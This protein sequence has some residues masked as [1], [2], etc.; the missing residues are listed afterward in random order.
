MYGEIN[1]VVICTLIKVIN[2]VKTNK[3]STEI[4]SMSKG[5][6][7]VKLG[8][9]SKVYLKSQGNLDLELDSIIVMSSTTH[10]KLF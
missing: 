9:R 6:D 3:L 7:I 10:H 2:V 8:S 4:V 5:P 1:I